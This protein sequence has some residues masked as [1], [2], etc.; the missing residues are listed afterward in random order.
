MKKVDHFLDGFFNP[1][2]VA[3]VGATNSRFKPNFRLMEN[4]VGLNFKGRIYPIN[5]GAREIYGI[6]AY[7]RLRDVPERIDLWSQ[8]SRPRRPWR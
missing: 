8:R 6:K 4:L 7:A 5:P 2:S 3:I 1:R